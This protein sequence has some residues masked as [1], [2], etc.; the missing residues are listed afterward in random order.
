M[1]FF[2]ERLLFLLL[3]N[4]VEPGHLH[5]VNFQLYCTL[6]P[7]LYSKTALVLIQLLSLY[8]EENLK[9]KTRYVPFLPVDRRATR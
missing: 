5:F 6:Y 9:N 8:F 7:S 3:K 4:I 1:H 2:R